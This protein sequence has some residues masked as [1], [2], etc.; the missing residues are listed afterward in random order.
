METDKLTA[1]LKNLTKVDIDAV[2]SYHQGIA[3]R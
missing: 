1:M 2:Y 3:D